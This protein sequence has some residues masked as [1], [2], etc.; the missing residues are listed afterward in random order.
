MSI[1][2]ELKRRNVFK[3]AAAYIIVSW[4][5]LQVGDLLAPA[6]RLPEWVTSALAFFVILGFPLA[7]VVAWAFEVTPEGIKLQKEVDRDQS[8]THIT[9]RRLDFW[10]IG[11]LAAAVI[12]FAF[13]RFVLAPE[14]NAAEIEQAVQQA[15]EAQSE[16]GDSQQATGTSI[17][18][19]PFVNMSNDP[20]QEFFSD[21]ISEE[22]LNVIARYPGLRV[23][24]RTSSFQFKG[25]NLDVAEIARK[26]R[27]SH[28]LEGSV[29]KA[30]DRIRI[31]AQLIE[32][33][34]GYHLWS[35]SYDRDLVDVFAIQDEISAA[36]GDAL[37]V[38]L[39]L[40]VGGAAIPTVAEAASIAAYEKYMEGRQL[41]HQRGRVNME[42]A[43][44]LL[45]AAVHEDPQYAPA[46][47]QLAIAYLML[48][49]NPGSYGDWPFPESKARA[50]PHIERA[51]ELDERLP[52]AFGAL[53]LAGIIEPDY[54]MAMRHAERALELNPSYADAINWKSLAAFNSGR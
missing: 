53:T 15:R 25:Q 42:R 47:A 8:I 1:F 14:R 36:I 33:E 2:Q 9:G 46:H 35:E 40:D 49:N 24:A 51:L 34:N 32:A 30:G 50:M 17:A 29:R 18:V 26:L 10:I 23:A 19:L 41:I 43:M 4:L 44:V 22:L 45:E 12:V 31:T 21:G 20:D 7:M 37:K 38:T 16:A 52:E 28:V 6:L 11:L 54:A 48:S 39:A 13:D 27:V 5:I 3:V